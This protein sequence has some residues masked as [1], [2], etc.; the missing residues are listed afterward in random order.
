MISLEVGRARLESDRTRLEAALAAQERAIAYLQSFPG[1]IG[2]P[3][4][5]F[6][7]WRGR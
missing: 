7:Q 2:W 1:W 5:R 4:R 6:R 3:W